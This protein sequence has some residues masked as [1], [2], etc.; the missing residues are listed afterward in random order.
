[1]RAHVT[2]PGE[3]PTDTFRLARKGLAPAM[4]LSLIA[5]AQQRR[6]G[7]AAAAVMAT[8]N[9][10]VAAGTPL[11]GSPLRTSFETDRDPASEPD[12]GVPLRHE[13]SA[14]GWLEL[15]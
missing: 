7:R 14:M 11:L 3:H 12:P 6:P 10:N 5:P 2:K 13:I 8:S 1:M 9:A 15:G 4:T